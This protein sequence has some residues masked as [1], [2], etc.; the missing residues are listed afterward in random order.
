MILNLILPQESIED[1][2]GDGEGASDIEV[3]R[4]EEGFGEEP[5]GDSKA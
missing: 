4:R 5:K 3:V 2:E 1:M